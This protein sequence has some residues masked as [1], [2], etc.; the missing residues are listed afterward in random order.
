MRLSVSE[1]DTYEARP[2]EQMI[3]ADAIVDGDW[4]WPSIWNHHFD[5]LNN[6][7]V[8]VLTDGKKDCVIW[9]GTKLGMMRWNMDWRKVIDEI[10][11]GGCNNTINSVLHRIVIATTV[12]FIWNERNSR[13]FNQS[14]RTSKCVLDGILENIKMHLLGLKVRRSAAVDQVNKVWDIQMKVV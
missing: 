1:K 10:A 9:K 14:Q 11:D 8:P 6:L 5:K 2:S 13:L 4:V 12:Y 3:V 7:E